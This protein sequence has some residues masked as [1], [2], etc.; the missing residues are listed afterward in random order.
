MLSEVHIHHVT[1]FYRKMLLSSSETS[2]NLQQMHAQTIVPLQSC[3][4][5]LGASFAEG[6]GYHAAPLTLQLALILDMELLAD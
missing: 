4:H 2:G 6:H 3:V 5:S 1:L